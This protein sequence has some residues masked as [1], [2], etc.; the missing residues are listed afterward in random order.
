MRELLLELEQ[1]V[2]Q[3]KPVCYTCLVE[4]RGSTPQKPGAAMLIFSDG[5][6]VGTLGAVVWKPKSNAVHSA[7]STRMPRKS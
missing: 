6:Q 7:Y 2:Q 4:T 5:S 3:Q 1:A